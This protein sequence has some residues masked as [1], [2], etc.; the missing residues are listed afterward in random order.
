[1]TGVGTIID[2]TPTLGSPASTW[3]GVY[4]RVL[5]VRDNG[6]EV[7]SI[8]PHGVVRAHTVEVSGRRVATV[9][10]VQNMRMQTRI[11]AALGAS[12]GVLLTLALAVLGRSVTRV[13]RMRRWLARQPEETSSP[14]RDGR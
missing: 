14:Y 6:K 11:D 5:S 7:A 9:E 3:S 13:V 12:Y 10:D 2:T 1:M 8:D 4:A